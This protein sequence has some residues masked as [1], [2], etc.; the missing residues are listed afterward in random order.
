[1][2]DFPAITAPDAGRRRAGA[3]PPG[4]VD[5]TARLARPARGAVG[6]GGGMPGGVPAA[7]VPARPG[8]GVRGRSRRHRRGGVGLSRRRSPRRWSRTSTPAAPRSTCSPRPRARACGWST[9][10]STST[11]HCRASIGAHKVRRGSGNIA[12]EDALTADEAQAAIEA[13]RRIAD[14]E[15]DA[16]ADLLIAGDMGI[17][18]TTAATTLIAALTGAEPVAVVG[19]GTGI[20]DAGWSRK[21][22]AV[23]D[24]LYRARG[25]ARRSAWAAAGVRRRGPRRDGGILRPGGGA[26]H[27]GAARRRGGDV[28]RVGRRR[29]RAGRPASGGTRDTGPP[30]PPTRWRWRSS[31]SNR[32]STSRCGSA[33]APA[34]RS[35]CPSC[36]PPSPHW[37]RW[38]RSTRPASRRDPF[39]HRGIRV[40]H[41]PA[42]ARAGP[43]SAGGSSTALPVVGRRARARWPPRWCGRRRRLSARATRWPACWRSRRCSIATRGLHIDGLADTVDGLGCYG[44]PERALQVMR[45]GSA[46]PV[47][48]GRRRGG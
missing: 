31:N 35:H 8:R 30:N 14:E 28:G 4:H 48:R 41:G 21:V 32:S 6:M 40:R 2:T 15:V 43:G 17:G 45:D 25:H 26:P 37:R 3:G 20:D 16:G 7:A 29:A 42:G 46:G 27:A 44:P 33:K 18:N 11:S 34:R 1:M 9:S 10:R 23:R 24:A 22:A 19:R 13:G 38:P 36:A 47:R 12:V 39:G 5:Q